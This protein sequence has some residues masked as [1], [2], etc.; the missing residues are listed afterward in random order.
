MQGP[1]VRYNEIAPTLFDGNDF[2]YENFTDGLKR[3]IWGY[4]KKMVIADCLV[5]LTSYCFSNP[6][7]IAGIEAWLTVLCF[8]I[9]DY[10][11]FSGYMDIACGVSKCLGVALRKTSIIRIL[12]KVSTIIG[13]DGI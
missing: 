9:Y 3:M 10:C 12:P 6:N 8:F 7:S 1:I 2:D 5:V 13:A 11:D 4:F